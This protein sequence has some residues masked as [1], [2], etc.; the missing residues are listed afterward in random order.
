[1]KIPVIPM[2]WLVIW[3]YDFGGRVVDDVVLFQGD[4]LPFQLRDTLN[5]GLHSL[6]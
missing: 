5:I 3:P 2:S 4:V 6:Q 1:M